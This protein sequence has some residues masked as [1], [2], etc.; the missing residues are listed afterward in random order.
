FRAGESEQIG[1]I[2]CRVTD[3]SWPVDVVGHDMP[4]VAALVPWRRETAW[5][6][7][8]A[9]PWIM[10]LGSRSFRRTTERRDPTGLLRDGLQVFDDRPALFIGEQWTNDPIAPGPI[11]ERVTRV[12]VSQQARIHD[13]RAWSAGRV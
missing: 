7:E 13:E 1:E 6:D 12:R 11:L 8:P 4:S 5:P 3:L 9:T 2:G 10:S